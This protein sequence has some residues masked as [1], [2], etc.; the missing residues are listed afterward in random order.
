M[1]SEML[2]LV[3]AA[4]DAANAADPV[5]G[6][7]LTYGRRMSD[8]LAAFAPQSSDVLQIAARAQHIER[9]SLPRD[10]YAMDRI[11]YLKW[12]KDLQQHHAKRTGELMAA[13]GYGGDEIARVASLLKKERLKSDD[14]TQTLEDVV[15]L[16][17][18]EHEA[19]DF[20]VRHDDAKV[21]DILGKTAKKM[22]PRG[23]AEIATLPLDPRLAKL[24][25]AL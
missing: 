8:R 11:G 6:R 25:A 15:C 4:I 16:V 24:I 3:L 22:S 18:L 1:A 5:A 21:S 7:A 20:I 17:F 2:K 14:E 9:W 23:L 19:P 12:R 10:K 13:A